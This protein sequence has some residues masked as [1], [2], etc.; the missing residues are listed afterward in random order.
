V[1]QA[2]I[3]R[4]F[5]IVCRR[6]KLVSQVAT[7]LYPIQHDTVTLHNIRSFVLVLVLKDFCFVDIK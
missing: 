1:C 6:A 5:Q 3:F 2:F 4:L 7:V